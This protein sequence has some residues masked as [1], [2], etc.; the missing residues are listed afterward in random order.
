MKY[1]SIDIETTGLNPETC[2]IVE[3]AAIADD[4]SNPQPL[5]S[6]FRFHCYVLPANGVYKG[7]PY[8]LS[9]HPESFRRISKLEGSYDYFLPGEVCANIQKWMY[10]IG[11]NCSNGITVAG[12]NFGIFDFQFLK[13]LP[14]WNLKINH[15][16]IDVGN[17]YLE[18]NDT[19]IPDSKECLKR[20]GIGG[21]VSHTAMEDALDVVKL[22]RKKMS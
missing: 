12:K 16:V 2:D 13:R 17:L 22:V 14:N 5:E 1:V 11:L 18:K 8:A 15:R 21:E 19:K 4:W 10:N 20:A 3:I 7:E 9:M 6:L